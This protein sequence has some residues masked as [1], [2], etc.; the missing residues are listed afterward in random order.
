M[1]ASE[2]SESLLSNF[3]SYILRRTR[4]IYRGSF[5]SNA[6]FN[7]C[8]RQKISVQRKGWFSTKAYNKVGFCDRDKTA[9]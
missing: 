8:A 7:L 5:R 4:Y 9:L 1:Q 6:S 3:L 2:Y